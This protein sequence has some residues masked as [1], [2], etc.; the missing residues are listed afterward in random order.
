[1][2]KKLSSFFE[3]INIDPSS[4]YIELDTGSSILEM[5]PKR[6]EIEPRQFL[7]YAYSDFELEG[8]HG[9]INALS[10]V[11]RAIESQSEVIHFSLGIPYENLSF[12]GKM[13]NIQKMGFSP[14]VILKHINKIRVDLEHFYKI[15]DYERVEDAVQIAQLFL[16]VTTLFLSNFWVSFNIFSDKEE[17]KTKDYRTFNGF[18][19]DFSKGTFEIE[20]WKEGVSIISIS[21]T[22]AE[23]EDYFLMIN[24]LIDLEKHSHNM[25]EDIQ[26]RIFQRFYA[27]AIE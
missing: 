14:S 24:L 15:P 10:N 20:F 25:N 21:I 7:E 4:Y 18:H 9:L 19:V 6:F 12:P 11:K 27:K 8:N 2:T 23:L 26:K 16:D 22:P 13:E 5:D 3:Q 17:N 1:M